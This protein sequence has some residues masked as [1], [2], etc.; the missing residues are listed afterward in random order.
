MEIDKTA[1]V[2]V[3]IDFESGE[4]YPVDTKSV[5]V[6]IK[7]N[8]VLEDA[9]ILLNGEQVDYQN[10][11][12]NYTFTIG[13][14]NS[15][16][17]VEIIS[18]DAAGNEFKAEVNDFLVSTNL[19]VRWYNNTPLFMGSISGIGIIGIAI[20]TYMVFRN[21]KKTNVSIEENDSIGG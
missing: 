7:D 1:P 13:S 12:E 19:F 16:Q 18:T 11:G 4:Q 21:K 17:D 3:P 9:R 15:K 2:I 8:L 6:S 5:T 14:S 20:T 10:D